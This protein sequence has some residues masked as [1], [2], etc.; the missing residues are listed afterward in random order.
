MRGVVRLFRH[1]A[2]I[3]RDTNIGLGMSRNDSV[4]HTAPRFQQAACL[5]AMR[6]VH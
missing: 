2:I 6:R 1:T 4:H 3:L 5:Y